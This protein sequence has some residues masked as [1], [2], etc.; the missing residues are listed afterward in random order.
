MAPAVSTHLSHRRWRTHQFTT[1]DR[2]SNQTQQVSPAD[3]CLG[4]MSIFRPAHIPT[5]VSCVQVQK[6]DG[7]TCCRIAI[8]M[9][10]R[11]YMCIQTCPGLM[12]RHECVL[13]SDAC[14][15]ACVDTCADTCADT[16]TDM[17]I[18]VW[19]GKYMHT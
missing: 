16:R 3:D 11:I 14:A 2:P 10:V 13:I 8:R 18:D 9:S 17:F 12:Y 1:T 4:H 6:M 19:K 15:D 7:T 5:H